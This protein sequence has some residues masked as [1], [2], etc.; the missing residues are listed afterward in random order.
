[1]GKAF[2]RIFVFATVLALVVFGG[3]WAYDTGLFK[4]AAE[5]DTSVPNPPAQ[6]EGED[7]TPKDAGAPARPGDANAEREWMT[8]FSPADPSTV[9][10]SEGAKAE[11]IGSGDSQAI[12]VASSSADASVT[13]DVGEG[14]LERLAGG[15]AVF[16]VI[17]RSEEGK[18]TQISIT[19][20]FAGFGDCGRK[21]YE[22]GYERGEYLFEIAFPQSAPGGAGSITIVSDLAN[23]GKAVEIFLIRASPAKSE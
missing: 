18:A 6:V 22:I 20:D 10:A 19:C 15:K 21:R 9:Q 8:V 12:R 5:R 17:A 2:A 13:F 7:F 11:I 14:I 3:W 1:M 23:A 16:D 4:S